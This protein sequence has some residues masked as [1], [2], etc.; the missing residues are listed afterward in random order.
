MRKYSNY[1]L[2]TLFFISLCFIS[3]TVFAADDVIW[4]SGLNLYFKLREQD[5]TR[6]GKNDHPVDLDSNTI[7]TALQEM[8]LLN[9]CFLRSK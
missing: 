1:Q 6:Y 5:D 3:G 9:P 7:S 4:K 8:K 2:F